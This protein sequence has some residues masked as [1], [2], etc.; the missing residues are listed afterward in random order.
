MRIALCS[1]LAFGAC[2]SVVLAEP[3][4]LAASADRATTPKARQHLQVPKTTTGPVA[5]TETEMDKIA[6]GSFQQQYHAITVDGGQIKRAQ[7][8]LVIIV[9]PHLVYPKGSQ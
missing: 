4:P 8:E 1:A 5:L 7:T 2:A 9:T 6:A 3:S